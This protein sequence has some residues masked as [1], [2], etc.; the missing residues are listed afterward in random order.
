VS[1]RDPALRMPY[2]AMVNMSRSLR[3]P[4]DWQIRQVEPAGPGEDRDPPFARGLLFAVPMSGLLW[5]ALYGL[6]RLLGG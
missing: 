1:D 3:Q 6:W 4:D 2:M 5:V